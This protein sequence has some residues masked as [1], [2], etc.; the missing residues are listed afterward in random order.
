MAAG[1]GRGTGPRVEGG[2][3]GAVLRAL[4]PALAGIA[5]I[6][7]GGGGLHLFLGVEAERGG[8]EWFYLNNE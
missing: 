8:V 3:G 6:E 5:G 7:E 4:G 2:I 1:Q